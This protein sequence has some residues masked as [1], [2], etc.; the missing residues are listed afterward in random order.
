MLIH[1]GSSAL[2]EFRLAKLRQDLA[3]SG[4]P[5][6]QVTAQ[7]IHLIK[8][9]DPAATAL[10]ADEQSTLEKLLTYGSHPIS[11]YSP[12]PS[13]F[14]LYVAPRPGTI[15]AWSSKATAIAHICGLIAIKRIERITAYT[16]AFGAEA[17]QSKI[18]NRKSKI[19]EAKLHDRM[20]ETVFTS[21]DDLPNLF[22]ICDGEP[23]PLATIPVLAQ[24][25]A[26]LETAN[27]TLALAL[28][29][30]EIDYLLN[31]FTTLKR[32]PNDI[33]L[34][35]FAQA[36]SE[37]CRHKIFNA[38]WDIDGRPQDRSL[39]QMI[40]NTHQHHS[41]GILSAY[42]DNSAVIAG[43]RAPRFFRD[44]VTGEYITR[45]EDI[46]IMCKAETHNH[47]TAISPFP[48]AS[49]AAG[50]EIRDEGATGRGARPKAG[51]CGI[52]VSNLRIPGALRPWE[53]DNGKPARIVSALDIALEAPQGAAAFNNEFGRPSIT[54]YFRTFEQHVPSS[55]GFQPV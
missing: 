40:K 4:I 1:H 52:T 17:P 42:K 9:A 53:T 29:D 21:L 14:S 25:R 31:A 15:T 48:G 41:A 51:L 12:Q 45:D 37:H 46:H 39:F 44:P 24:G 30:D 11:A 7:F 43:T 35:M 26:A 6:E 47:P 23:R 27:T 33:E 28:A 13:G 55:T 54:G 19:L 3:A 16:F 50:G 18:E 22:A 38:T 32:D 34:M 8:L 20:R 10:P 2:P 5:V 49:T 36:N